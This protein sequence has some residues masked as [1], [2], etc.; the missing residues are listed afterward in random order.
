MNTAY[1]LYEDMIDGCDRV[2]AI[3]DK[4]PSEQDIVNVLISRDALKYRNDFYVVP[5]PVYEVR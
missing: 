3:F 5:F 4:T 1:I 2:A